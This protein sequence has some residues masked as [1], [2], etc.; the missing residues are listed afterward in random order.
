MAMVL[1]TLTVTTLLAIFSEHI[2]VNAGLG[3]DGGVYAHLALQFERVLSGGDPPYPVTYFRYLPSALAFLCLKAS[4][5]PRTPEGAVAAFSMVNI[6]LYSL[7]ALAWSRVAT[8]MGLSRRGAWLGWIC[9]FVNYAVLKY[10]FYYPTLTDGTAQAMSVFLL[11]DYVFGRRWRL[12]LT[13]ILG[14]FTWPVLPLVGCLLWLFPVKSSS[15]ES[16]VSLP[17]PVAVPLAASGVL[18]VL[19]NAQPLFPDNLDS[20]FYSALPL[21]IGMSVAYVFIMLWGVLRTPGLFDARRNRRRMLLAGLIVAAGATVLLT[22]LGTNGTFAGTVQ[23]YVRVVFIAGIRRPGEFLV[24]HTLYFGPVVLLAV[25]LAPAVSRAIGRFGWGLALALLLM[26]YQAQNPLSRQCLVILPFLVLP[27]TL[28]MDELRVPV[29]FMVFFGFISLLI[30]KV[31]YCIS[32]GI[33]PSIPGDQD[34]IFWPRYVSSTGF[35]MKADQ[36]YVQGVLI[37]LALCFLFLYLRSLP[38]RT[39]GNG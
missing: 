21:G 15:P 2:H 14:F 37:A 27:V 19:V 20:Q 32:Y 17:F 13:S 16:T 11:H 36:Y 8:A 25:C 38:R 4:G 35:W 39:G 30:S 18:L 31:W 22:P 9:L 7:A 29:S 6:I 5:L 12:L 26:G 33:D 3:W 10:S 34:P 28:A 23:D 1:A 24:A